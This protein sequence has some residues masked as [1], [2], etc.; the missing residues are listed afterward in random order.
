MLRHAGRAVP[1][2]LVAVAAVG[3]AGLLA[4]VRWRPW[5]LWPLE[6]VAVGL[7]AAAVGWCL[8]EPAAAVVDV[9][10]RGIAWRTAARSA[11]VA[12]LLAAWA[13]GVWFARDGLF[14][15][16][17]YVLL[18]GGGAAAVAVA[19]TT[20]RRVGGEATPGGRWAVVVVPLTSAW[21]L[22]RP[23]EASAPVFP[24][25]DQGWAASAAGWVAAG[26]GAATVLAVVLVRD[27]R[28]SVR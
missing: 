9:T 8:D 6:G 7:L 24:F 5:T 4:L 1:W 19:W 2:V 26:L 23:F 20:W 15:H 12:V 28:G 22:V 3:V 10:P 17:G 25:A 14:G 13:T 27:G 11:G 21:A 18:Q 16:P